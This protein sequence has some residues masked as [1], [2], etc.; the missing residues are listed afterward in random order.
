MRRFLVVAGFLFAGACAIQAQAVDT[1]VCDVLKNPA[2]FNGKTVRIKGTVSAGL[3]QFIVRGA[4][5]GQPVDAIWL[6]YPEGTKGKAAPDATVELQPA[7]N[8]AGK[9]TAP[10]RTP[11]KL[12]KD[13][14]FK[15]FDSLLAEEHKGPYLCLGCRRY[16]VSATLVGRLDGV[17]D[18]SLQRDA[19]GKITG[20]GG[21]G[22]MNAYSA[23]LVLQSVSDVS[24]K[25]IDYSKAD[26]LAKGNSPEVSVP[27]GQYDPLD[28]AHR[29]ALAIGNVPAGVQAQKDAEVY[30][31]K[32]DNNG[33]NIGFGR[34]NEVSDKDGAPGTADSPDGVLYTCTFN[35]NHLQGEAMAAAILHI[36]NHVSELRAPASLDQIEPPYILE[37]NAWA[38]TIS[39]AM[40][41]RQKF[42]VLPGGYVGWDYKWPQSDI[43]SNFASTMASFFSDEALM[44]R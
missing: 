17:A 28:V 23:R 40:G 11:V 20:L 12:E 39:A 5:C 2:S 27:G 30:G 26:A 21:F 41:M 34:M 1:T 42:L 15:Q 14:A 35:M 16:E 18:A 19:S 8:F 36:G 3:D 32:G 9:Y 38:I 44:S 7:H 25:E 33:V 29:A 37:A 31:K 10:T 24:S 6:A 43:S 13:K 22:N 4:D